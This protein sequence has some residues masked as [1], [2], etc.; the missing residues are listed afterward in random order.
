MTRNKKHMR[1]QSVYFALLKYANI[2]NQN[3]NYLL[4]MTNLAF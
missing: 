4:K 3:N 2:D 1:N